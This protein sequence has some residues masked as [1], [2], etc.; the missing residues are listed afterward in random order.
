ALRRLRRSRLEGSNERGLLSR[1]SRETPRQARGERLL[2][3]RPISPFA[4]EKRASRRASYATS[5]TA[6]AQRVQR[7]ALSSLPTSGST[8][9][10]RAHFSPSATLVTT[11]IPA[12]SSSLNAVWGDSPSTIRAA[13]VIKVS[14]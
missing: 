2:K 4:R 12:T 3:A 14:A 8:C 13:D 6:S 5:A 1:R 7:S 10:Q 11:P 9:Q